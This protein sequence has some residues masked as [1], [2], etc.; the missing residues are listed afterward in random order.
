MD[1][2]ITKTL[3][4]YSWTVFTCAHV[5]LKY[6]NNV[7]TTHQNLAF[8][9][10]EKIFLEKSNRILMEPHVNSLFKYITVDPVFNW[11]PY[12]HRNCGLSY[13]FAGKQPSGII[14]ENGGMHILV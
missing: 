3:T 10:G 9:L 8:H 7:Q 12:I 11:F 2:Q 14:L 1:L 6:I 13:S 5:L 4:N